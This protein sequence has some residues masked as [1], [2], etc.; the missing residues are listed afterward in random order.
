MALLN[1]ILRQRFFYFTIL[2]LIKS[3][4]AWFVV[5]NEGPSLMTLVTE[6]PFFWAV[7]CVIEWLAGKRKMLYYMITNLL[8]TLLYF[9]VLMYYKYYGVIVTYHAIAQAD[10]VTKVG[11]STYSLLDPY[12]LLIFID[13]V[14]LTALLLRPKYKA[15]RQAATMKPVNRKVLT[16]VFVFSVGLCLFNIWPNRASMNENKQAEEM[17][18]LNYE[19]YTIFADTSEDEEIVDKS[20]ITQAAINEL[21]GVSPSPNPQYY[22]SAKGKNLIILQMES[23][24]DF[25]IGL[26]IDGQEVT[27][28]MNKLVKETFHFDHFYTMVGQGTTSDAEY[29][30]NTSMYVPKHEAATEHYVDKALPSLPKLLQANGYTTATFHTNSVEFW[31]RKELYPSLGWEKYYD[32]AFFGDDDHVAFGASDA[33]LYEKT[34]AKLTEMDKSEQPFYA[35]VISMSAHHPFDL[36]E[37]KYHMTLPEEM[38]GTLVGNYIHA[39]NYADYELGKFLEGL[40]TSGLWDD[41]VI[42]FYGDH[43][44][45]SLYSLKNNEKEMLKDLLGHEYGYTEMFKIPLVIHAPGVTYQST[46]EKT[47][48]EIDIAPTAVNLLGISY[49]NQI[50]FGQDLL[51]NDS[52]VLPMRHFLP[53]GSIVTETSMFLTG[54]GF[55]DGTDYRIEDSAEIDDK[56]NKATE[57]QYLNGLRLLQ[58]SD[59]YVKQLPDK[60]TTTLITKSGME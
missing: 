51:N 42:M 9:T 35:Q 13:I 3:V 30:V 29:V 53:T 28:N 43:Q 16:Y 33:I 38:E 50:H 36:P 8:L 39:Q 48:G 26:K 37:E 22:G 52:N 18:I 45:L 59:S 20:E 41:S 47:G 57:Q 60:S 7:F 11:N 25:L 15:I 40:K 27:P 34:L 54:K 4:I 2:I 10:K 55:E 24:Q 44:G 14:V 58:L 32:Q 19:V 12:Y 56:D 5:F 21:K 6:I 49:D 1:R 46:I 31:N 23:F 17:G